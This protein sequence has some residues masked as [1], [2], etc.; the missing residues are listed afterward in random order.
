M[1]TRY[2]VNNETYAQLTI[3]AALFGINLVLR[4]YDEK[5]R[6]I[7]MNYLENEEIGEW[8]LKRFNMSVLLWLVMFLKIKMCKIK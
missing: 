1:H 4:M 3:F 5:S 2:K 8:V 7:A 6:D